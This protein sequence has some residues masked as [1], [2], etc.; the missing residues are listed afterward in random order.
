MK[1]KKYVERA[2]SIRSITN[3][4]SLFVIIQTAKVT[5]ARRC[6]AIAVRKD[7]RARNDR[8]RKENQQD[9]GNH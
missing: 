3:V 9:Q 5:D 1:K 8:I 2:N 7:G 4:A 6:I